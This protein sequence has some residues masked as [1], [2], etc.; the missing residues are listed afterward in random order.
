MSDSRHTP[1]RAIR[2]SDSLWERAQARADADGE[3]VSQAIRRFLER[4]ARREDSWH[5]HFSPAEI[6]DLFA[7]VRRAEAAYREES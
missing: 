1:N 3:S 4:Y 6:D 5:A 2:I 7:R